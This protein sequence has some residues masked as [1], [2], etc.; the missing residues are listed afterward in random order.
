LVWYSQGQRPTRR[1]ETTQRQK[2]QTPDRA[3]Q[4]NKHQGQP[5]GKRQAQDKNQ[6]KSI[7]MGII[8]TQFSNH[9]KPE[10]TNTSGNQEADIK[11]YLMKIIEFF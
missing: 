11:S 2:K 6:Q 1:P 8:R 7:Y 4:S 9:R 3:Y 10:Y 5:D